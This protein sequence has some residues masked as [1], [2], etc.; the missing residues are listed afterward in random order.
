MLADDDFGTGYSSL[1]YL[2]KFPVDELKIDR[3]FIAGTTSAFSD[4]EALVHMLVELGRVLGL[5]TVAEGIE[6]NS[7]LSCLQAAGCAYGQGYL[8]ARPLG[9]VAI[10][11]FFAAHD[12]AAPFHAAHDTAA[13]FHAATGARSAADS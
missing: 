8:F 1:A 3:S 12:T 6:T 10:E 11:P 2:K 4:Q 13:P 9:P 5:R 7:E